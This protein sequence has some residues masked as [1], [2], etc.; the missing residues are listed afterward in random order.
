MLNFD[1]K[2]HSDVDVMLAADNCNQRRARDELK[3]KLGNEMQPTQIP[4]R[5]KIDELELR[6][7]SPH[8]RSAEGMTWMRDQKESKNR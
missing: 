8:G 1:A 6:D 2:E 5:V 3:R 7:P 4:C